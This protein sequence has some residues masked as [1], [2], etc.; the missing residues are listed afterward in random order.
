MDMLFLMIV[1][2]A[3]LSFV[4]VCWLVYSLIRWYVGKEFDRWTE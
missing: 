4:P 1:A 3:I 2:V